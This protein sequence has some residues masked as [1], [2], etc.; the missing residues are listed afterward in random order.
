MSKNNWFCFV[1]KLLRILTVFLGVLILQ[2]DGFGQ[3]V[4]RDQGRNVTGGMP[5]MY[6]DCNVCDHNYIRQEITFVNHVRDQ[7]QSDIHIFVTSVGT[8]GGG[9]EYEASFIGRRHYQQISFTLFFQTE[10]GDTAAERRQKITETLKMGLAPFLA[11]T[12]YAPYFSL[13]HTPPEGQEIETQEEDDPWNSWTFEIYAG[14]INL[15]KE[16]NKTNF[17]SRWGFWADRVT[18][19]WKLR[20]R[21]YFNYHYEDVRESESD[22]L[23]ISRRHR[24]GINSYAIKSLGP[25]WSAGLFGNYLT[26]ND[27][28]LKHQFEI[29]PG[30][31]YSLLPYKEAMRR[32]ITFRYRLGYT[33]RNYYEETIY[34]QT[35]EHLLNHSLRASVNIRQTWGNINTSIF[36]SHYFHDTNFRRANVSTNISVRLTEGLS[37]SFYASYNLIQDQLSLPAG[38]VTLEEILL[39][40]RE[41]ATDYD[42]YTSIAIHYAFGSSFANVVNTRF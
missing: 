29:T 30:V 23:V 28:N 1:T 14:S 37:L 34:E 35:S 41:L 38:E 8:G 40:Q 27:R 4:L 16:S 22:N 33:N 7:Q 17:N 13:E 26:Q 6:L 5:R 15:Y 31:E 3:E 24:H 36:G 10:R 20:F 9:T 18:D 39:N 21:P 25:H 32:A 2:V 19:D 42:L 11:T 12:R